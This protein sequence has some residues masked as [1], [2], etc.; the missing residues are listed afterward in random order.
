VVRL[1]GRSGSRLFIYVYL[2]SGGLS[3]I[4]STDIVIMTLTPIIFYCALAARCDPIP[5]LY[6][7]F[8][9]GMSY[10]C[11]RQASIPITFWMFVIGIANVSSILFL[12]GNVTNVI[13]GQATDIS[14][15]Q[16]CFLNVSRPVARS[17]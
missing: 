7:S 14:F 10:S 3:A 16:V 17:H 13:I 2:A 8:Y 4:T 5:L 15:V 9:G 1:A 11:I 12:V 6:A